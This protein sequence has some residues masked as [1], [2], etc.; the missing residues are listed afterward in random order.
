MGSNV[1]RVT[2]LDPKGRAEHLRR[3]REREAVILSPQGGAGIDARAKAVL[4]PA[5]ADRRRLVN[6][7]I[8]A[9]SRV[10]AIVWLHRAADRLGQAVAHEVACRR[11]CDACCHQDVMV[12]QAEA[13]L[14]GRAIGRRPVTTPAGAV[15]VGRDMM[16]PPVVPVLHSGRPCTFLKG[17]ECSIFRNRPLMCR[18]HANFDHDALLCQIVPGE[19]ISVP[20]VDTS[21]EKL[22]YHGKV[23]AGG[24]VADIRD[25]FP[26][27]Q[28]EER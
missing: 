10:K 23:A 5:E 26:P 6:E 25:W 1:E 18:L 12:S 3:V 9:T 11:G 8:R 7:A 28:Q 27:G 13:D 16:E 4:R 17:G 14:I 15:A 24:L 2:D 19:S 22:V 21:I 20:Y